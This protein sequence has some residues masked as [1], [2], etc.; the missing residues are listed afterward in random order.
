[1]KRPASSHVSGGTRLLTPAPGIIRA[2]LVG[3]LA[4]I[5]G[6]ALTATSG[7]L[8]VTASTRPVILTLLT[9]IVCVRAFGIGRPVFRYAE[10]VL[11]HDAAL[12]DLVRRRVATYRRLIPLTPVGLG[13]RRRGDLMAGV[14]HDLD[15]EVDVQVRAVVPA[16]ACAATALVAM[17]VAAATLPMAGVVVGALVLTAASAMTACARWSARM[18]HRTQQARADVHSTAHLVVTNT[19]QLQSISAGDTAMTWLG[20]SHRALRHAVRRQSRAHAVSTG[21]LP[22]L[23]GTATAAMAVCVH[24]GLASHAVSPAVAAMLLLLP[25]ALTD[26]LGMLPDACEAMIRGIAAHRRLESL[27]EQRIPKVTEGTQAAA[28]HTPVIELDAVQASWTGT[29]VDLPPTTARILPG[30][31]V[32]VLGPNGAGK[33]TLLAVLS[34][35]LPVA[36]ATLRIDGRDAS[37]LSAQ[38]IRRLIAVVDD[39]PHIFAGSVR[40]NLLLAR[41]GATDSELYAA[42]SRAGLNHWLS[43]L[44]D[45]LDTL[46]GLGGQ[47]V[48]GGERVRLAIARALVSQRPV[49]LLDEPVAHLDHPTAV[50]VMAD[51]HAATRG[52]TVLLV[53]HQQDGVEGCDHTLRIGDSATTGAR[54]ASTRDTVMA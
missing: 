38:S 35:H 13:R 39:E 1:M 23:I 42:L 40:A 34:R 45:G 20:D 6:V 19:P 32:A 28:R 4:S 21:L 30:D 10:R 37:T 26:T 24:T 18:S 49:L 41:P 48:S 3:S 47:S 14:V 31:H 36:A 12:A 46:L 33:S 22:A 51:L 52:C 43:D 5:C 27:L 53:S 11:A 17:I 2:S 29:R 8:I 7:W 16:V 44:P 9:A 54:H 25:V 15:D 50:Q